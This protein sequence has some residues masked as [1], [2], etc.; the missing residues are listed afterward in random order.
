MMYTYIANWS[1]YYFDIVSL[2]ALQFLFETYILIFILSTETLQFLQEVVNAFD[3]FSSVALWSTKSGKIEGQLKHSLQEDDQLMDVVCFDKCVVTVT[4]QGILAF[5]DITPM[6]SDKPSE[7]ILVEQIEVTD[8][9]K[10]VSLSLTSAVAHV[11]SFDTS[12]A[13]RVKFLTHLF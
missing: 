9:H 8:F 2:Q 5:W 7:A 12:A 3:C 10:L 4:C 13:A 11:K 1:M 6:V